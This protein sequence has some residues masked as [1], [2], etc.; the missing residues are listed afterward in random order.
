MAARADPIVA[1]RPF[2]KCVFTAAQLWSTLGWVWTLII[3]HLALKR[4]LQPRNTK[5][6]QQKNKQ[7]EKPIKIRVCVCVWVWGGGGGDSCI[8]TTLIFTITII[9]QRYSCSNITTQY[10]PLHA[11][12]HSL[13]TT[14]VACLGLF[15]LLRWLEAWPHLKGGNSAEIN[16]YIIQRFYAKGLDTRGLKWYKI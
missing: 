3:Q 14:W 5:K 7:K 8:F 9:Q 12:T 13:V 10:D 6:G 15:P 2:R 4:N 11:R 16:Q 1:P